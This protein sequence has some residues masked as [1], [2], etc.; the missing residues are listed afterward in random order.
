MA[1]YA[2]WNNKGGVGKSYLTFQV[3]CEYA[4]QHPEQNILVIDACPQANSSMMFLGGI[5]QGESHL[6]SL[7][8]VTPLRTISGYIEDRIRSPYVSLKTGTTY[9]HQ[10]RSFNE[11]VPRNVFIVPG[12][13]QLEVQASRVSTATNPGPPDAWRIVHQWFS[14]LISEIAAAWDRPYTVFIDCNPSFTVYTELALSASDRIIV[15]FT[16]DGSSKRAV[17]TLLALVYGIARHHGAQQSQ[18]FLNS[19]TFRM[20]IPNIYSYVGNRLTQNIGPASAFR[21]VVNEIGD[22]IYRVWQSNPNRFVIHPN[23][24]PPPRSRAEF[25]KMFQAEI[26][27][28]NSASVV[29]GALGIPMHRLTAGAKDLMGRNVTVNQTQLDSLRPNLEKFVQTIE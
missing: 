20:T 29:S 7:A 4:R 23:S 3:A 18:Y 15:P 8:T 12:D 10:A 5:V 2:F 13:E 25:K 11:T 27:D 26:S 6:D 14:D 1:T 24:S 28:A 9:V 22:E 16:A 19:N 21:T 17:R